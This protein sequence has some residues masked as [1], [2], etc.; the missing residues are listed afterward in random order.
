MEQVFL[1]DE[2]DLWGEME[3]GE[4]YINNG[5]PVHSI[6]KYDNY[7][8][9]LDEIQ[10]HFIKQINELKDRYNKYEIKV[11]NIN[12]HYSFSS[13]TKKQKLE[14][15]ER[16]RQA[17]EK[18]KE[19]A[20]QEEAKQEKAKQEKVKQEEEERKQEKQE[21]E[22][23][24][25]K[26]KIEKR[27]LFD[28]KYKFDRIYDKNNEEHIKINNDIMNRIKDLNHTMYNFDEIKKE[29]EELEISI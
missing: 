12:H 18:K 10:S 9:C 8:I 5:F 11:L 3:N 14:I 17:E 1:N 23:Q 22:N 15:E 26:L 6:I 2:V 24:E 28:L 19:E 4:R 16:R 20:K 7:L 13:L 29:Y 25:D 21:E 27:K